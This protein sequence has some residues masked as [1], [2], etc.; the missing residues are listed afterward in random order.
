[1]RSTDNDP[2]Y[3]E[4]IWSGLQDIAE[5]VAEATETVRQGSV[6]VSISIRSVKAAPLC[7]N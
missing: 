4:M 3:Q 6:G 2:V 1:M 5:A 7:I